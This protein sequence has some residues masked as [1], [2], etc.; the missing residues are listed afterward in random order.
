M[1]AYPVC[2]L[3]PFHLKFTTFQDSANFQKYFQNTLANSIENSN[4]IFYDAYDATLAAVGSKPVWVT[5][6]GWPV[7]GPTENLAVPSTQNAQSYWD[8]V[9]CSLFGKVNTWWYTLQDAAPT[10]PSPSFG[11]VGSSLTTTPLYNLQCPAISSASSSS[12]TTTSSSVVSVASASSSSVV[13]GSAS[14][15][16]GGGAGSTQTPVPGPLPAPSISSVS[17]ASVGSSP[18][19]PQSTASTVAATPIPSTSSSSD[20]SGSALG[21]SSTPSSLNSAPVSQNVPT[22]SAAISVQ[23]SSTFAT[24]T[25]TSAMPSTSPSSSSCPMDLSGQFEYPHLIVPIDKSQPDTAKGTSYNGTFSPTISSVYNFDI[26]ASDA[27]KTCSLVFFLPTQSQLTSSSYT[28]TGT[29]GMTI[30]RLQSPATQQTTYNTCPAVAK[31]SLLPRNIESV[32]PGNDYII[33]SG[34]CFAGARVAWEIS[35]TGSLSL[36]Y[37]QDYS[38]APIGLYITVC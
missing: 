28:L 35:A 34:S 7:S 14:S 10:T 24:I 32:T 9:G 1:D 31:D 20:A 27:G 16:V 15:L 29:G 38:P 2:I 18:S 13:T 23:G 3:H 19:N 6:T 11:I 22:S 8:Q 36:N 25:K 21:L 12:A 37:F 33:A 5:E 4:S 30:S 17:P 26:P